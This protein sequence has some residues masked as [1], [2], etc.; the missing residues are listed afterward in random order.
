[1]GFDDVRNNI[2]ALDQASGNIEVAINILSKDD[3]NSN[4]EEENIYSE[5]PYADQIKTLMSMGFLVIED[6]IE[7]L[8]KT[9]GN[10]EDAIHMLSKTDANSEPSQIKP[11]KKKEE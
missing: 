1:M 6:N 9:Y 2:K 11:P 4:K 5:S 3:S 8:D 7:V 10:L